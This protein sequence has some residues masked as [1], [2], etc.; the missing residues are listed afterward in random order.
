M[1]RS[2]CCRRLTMDEWM[3]LMEEKEKRG[4]EPPR[5]SLGS[6]WRQW[7]WSFEERKRGQKQFYASSQLVLHC[8]RREDCCIGSLRR[9]AELL[10]H[11]S[12][13]LI[14]DIPLRSFLSLHLSWSK[15]DQEEVRAK[16]H[17]EAAARGDDEDQEVGLSRGGRRRRKF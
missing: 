9:H 4:M 3:R 14:H 15:M 7:K 11:T 16:N 12:F 5:S 8:G 2:S 1:A 13:I 6:S 17:R 10:L